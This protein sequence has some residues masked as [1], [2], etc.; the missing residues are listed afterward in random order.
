MCLV[1]APPKRLPFRANLIRQYINIQRPHTPAFANGRIICYLAIT[2]FIRSHLHL[3][4]H[5]I[6]LQHGGG[7]CCFAFRANGHESSE[8]GVL[9]IY[10]CAPVLPGIRSDCA[11][12]TPT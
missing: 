11:S 10:R 4:V 9:V 3:A 5:S 12:V 2:C 8:A 6:L 7:S 1:Q